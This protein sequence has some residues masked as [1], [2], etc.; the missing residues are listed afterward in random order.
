MESSPMSIVQKKKFITTQ[1]T[2]EECIEWV[3]DT[4][5]TNDE[6]ITCDNIHELI[7]TLSIGHINSLYDFLMSKQVSIY[8][9]H[10][11][12]YNVSLVSL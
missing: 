4:N 12:I 10:K 8:G 3:K 1:L 11:D 7:N 5:I 6:N 9:L 2:T